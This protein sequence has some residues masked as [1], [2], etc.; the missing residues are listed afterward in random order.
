[1]IDVGAN[2]GDS[3]CLAR[4][5]E[6]DRFLLVEGSPRFHEILRSNAAG[7]SGVTVINAL[8]DEMPGASGG[9]FI[10][11][12]G[13]ARVAPGPGG[14]VPK[15]TLDQLTA[16]PDGSMGWNLLKTDID[17]F[18]LRALHGARNLL[19]RERPVVFLEFHPN[20]LDAAGDDPFRLFSLFT[21]LDYP[22]LLVY[23]NAGYLIGEFQ[24]RDTDRWRQLILLARSRPYYYFD[25]VAFPVEDS[26]GFGTFRQL[27]QAYYEQDVPRQFS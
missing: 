22:H 12:E 16:P 17:G 14:S 27:E 1:M 9:T 3:W 26:E 15:A 23:D 25:I 11:R 5:I 7:S 18:D 10:L 13:T 24:T 21:S 20:L 19:R 8:I 6:G 4:P 2:V